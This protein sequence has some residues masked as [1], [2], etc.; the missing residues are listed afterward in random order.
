MNAVD[1]VGSILDRNATG[2]WETVWF[3]FP[4]EFGELLVVKGSVAVDGVSLTVVDVRADRFSAMLI[5]HTR[6]NT[7]LGTKMPGDGVNLEFDLLA[8]HV[9]KLVAGMLQTERGKYDR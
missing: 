3:G 4:P 9:R 7:T 2:E 1:C 8:K 6:E 5:P